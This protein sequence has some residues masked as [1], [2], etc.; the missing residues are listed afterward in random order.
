[1]SG[2]RYVDCPRCIAFVEKFDAEVKGF[3]KTYYGKIDADE[4]EILRKR[5]KKIKNPFAVGNSVRL[6]Y[7]ASFDE[8]GS[9]EVEGYANCETCGLQAEC[10]NRA[11]PTNQ[12][13]SQAVFEEEMRKLR[14]N[15]G[16]PEAV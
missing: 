11:P 3:L 2:D 1:M 5:L 12:S 9:F 15:L 6:D 4:Y 13:A 8:D 7:S 16:L 14:D 10:S